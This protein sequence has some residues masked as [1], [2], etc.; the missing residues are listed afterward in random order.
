MGQSFRRGDRWT[1]AFQPCRQ[2][3]PIPGGATFTRH[4]QVVGDQEGGHCFASIRLMLRADTPAGCRLA[5]RQEWPLDCHTA[6][7]HETPP[8]TPASAAISLSEEE[9]ALVAPEL[10]HQLRSGD[11]TARDHNIT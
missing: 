6:L 10:K 8:L 11:A 9:Q 3:Q 2:L 1:E 7:I 4:L 5:L